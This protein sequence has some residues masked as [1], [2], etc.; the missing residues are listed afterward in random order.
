[1]KNTKTGG[2]KYPKMPAPTSHIPQNATI[3]TGNPVAKG[4][5]KGMKKMC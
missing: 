2:T 1:M 4:S 3:S 5:G